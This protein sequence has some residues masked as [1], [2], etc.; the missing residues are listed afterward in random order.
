MAVP[1][2]GQIS[3]FGF[4]KELEL[5]DYDSTIPIST[6]DDYYAMPISLANMATGHGGFDAINEN[7]DAADRPD[8]SEPHAMSE[9]YSYDHDAVGTVAY[10]VYGAD[11]W[12]D[13]NI[14]TGTRDTFT[15]TALE[16]NSLY[17]NTGADNTTPGTREERLTWVTSPATTYT[18]P[19]VVSDQL[20][21]RNT[22]NPH[23]MTL[24]TTDYFDWTPLNYI[25]ITTIP[26]TD[27]IA[28]RYRFYMNTTN[29]KDHI[30]DIRMNTINLSPN[31]GVST[32]TYQLQMTDNSDPGGAGKILFRHRNGTT[33][34]T[35]A[36]APG[37]YS[38]G[39]TSDIV[40]SWHRIEA[41]KGGPDQYGWRVGVGPT[42]ETTEN[43]VD[44][45]NKL[46][47]VDG[48]Y[49]SNFGWN[50][51]CPK[52][53]STPNSTHYHAFDAFSITQQ[54]DPTV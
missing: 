11:D 3:L 10:S 5:N 35:L 39:T 52:A 54:V 7:N 32:Q 19:V 15:E 40:V 51:R 47:A 6:Y 30:I 17:A 28:W 13:G 29:N 8:G 23:G 36:T 53:M 38:L 24:K 9:F 21:L 46:A 16:S 25:N 18:Q 48:T 4:A 50:F 12:D 42:T 22:N 27:M 14:G 43:I 33:V 34:T 44:D 41:T 31:P 2:T 26:Y 45:Y 49:L 1:S 37:A 20:R